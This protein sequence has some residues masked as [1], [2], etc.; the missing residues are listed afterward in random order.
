MLIFKVVAVIV[1][2]AILA[3]MALTGRV[4]VN[5]KPIAPLAGVIVGPVI[6]VVVGVIALIAAAAFTLPIWVWFIP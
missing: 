4:K 2:F 3:L 1:W 5:G 6:V